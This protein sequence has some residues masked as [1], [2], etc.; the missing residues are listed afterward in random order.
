MIRKVFLER[1]QVSFADMLI[2]S[3]I[4]AAHLAEWTESRFFRPVS[5]MELKEMIFEDVSS[6]AE[7]DKADGTVLFPMG[8]FQ[9]INPFSSTVKASFR[10]ARLAFPK[11][12]DELLG[13]FNGS[14]ID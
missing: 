5:R 13:G 4:V 1:K 7:R 3:F 9:M 8:T 14:T 2:Y 10:K 6:P 11:K 12:K